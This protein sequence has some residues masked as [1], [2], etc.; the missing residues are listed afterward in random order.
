[1]I[2]KTHSE[3]SKISFHLSSF[4]TPQKYLITAEDE[5]IVAIKTLD[6]LDGMFCAVAASLGVDMDELYASFPCLCIIGALFSKIP[7][8][9]QKIP[10]R[11]CLR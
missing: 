3:T 6:G 7:P 4:K 1:M 5:R 10:L 9:F 11:L 2:R 8:Q